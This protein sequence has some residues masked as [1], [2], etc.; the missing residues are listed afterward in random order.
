MEQRD[1]TG[2]LSK[3]TAPDGGARTLR[4]SGTNRVLC[5]NKPPYCL[6]FPSFHFASI[7]CQ[8]HSVT[9]SFAM[10]EE[11]QGYFSGKQH[12]FR[13]S[14]YW[15]FLFCRSRVSARSRSAGARVAVN[16]ALI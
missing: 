5:V 7:C 10:D 16:T 15:P 4:G 9:K 14:T 12:H 2:V 13:G 6:L 3:E 1:T 11:F 8:C